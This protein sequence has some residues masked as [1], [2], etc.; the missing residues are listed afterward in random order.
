VCNILAGTTVG[1]CAAI[2]TSCDVDGTICSGCGACCSHFCGPFGTFGSSICQPASGCHVQG[3]T[4]QTNSDCCG[5][6]S[7]SGL[8]G[9][10]QV[11]CVRDPTY[12]TKIGTCSKP[13]KSNC[14]PGTPGC[15]NTCD[16]AGDICH[17]NPS[18]ICS[19]DTTNVRNDCC[20]CISTKT[21]CQPD[22]VGI[23][24]CNLTGSCVPAGGICSFS[25]DCCNG[26]PCVP[27]STGTLHCAAM[28][29]PVGGL[30]TTNADCCTGLDCIVPP[31]SLKGTCANPNPPPPDMARPIV[32]LAGVDLRGRDLSMPPPGDMAVCAQYG[33]SCSTTQPCCNSNV[34][35]CTNTSFTTCKASDTNCSCF[36]PI[37]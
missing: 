30:C 16:P 9:A 23:P 14:P 15:T 5:G 8:P 10:G 32:D 22:K 20:S 2:S 7:T 1:T 27:D 21:C 4:C 29:V 13:N 6:D 31:G 19:G 18:P 11:V 34:V 25:G 37:Q 36:A 33:Q 28:C 26:L 12:P 35:P 3:D 24:R 17:Q